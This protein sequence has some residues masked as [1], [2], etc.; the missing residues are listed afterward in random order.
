MRISDLGIRWGT[1]DFLKLSYIKVGVNMCEIVYELIIDEID[2]E[3]LEEL[4][5][6]VKEV[7]EKYD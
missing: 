6:E 3:T 2:E 1:N 7:R 5:K 4:L